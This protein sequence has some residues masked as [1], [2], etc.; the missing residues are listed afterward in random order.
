[1]LNVERPETTGQVVV[2]FAL[3]IAEG[4]A[5]DLTLAKDY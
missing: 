4:L 2:T 1:M 3:V 5:Q